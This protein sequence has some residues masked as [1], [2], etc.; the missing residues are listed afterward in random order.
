MDTTKKIITIISLFLLI[1]AGCGGECKKDSDCVKK[2]F[3]GSCQDKV[4]QYDPLPNC[5]GNNIKEN[6]EDGKPGNECTCPLDYGQCSAK[7]KSS[8]YIQYSCNADKTECNTDVKPSI[9]VETQQITDTF[10]GTGS[11]KFS[12]VSK[13]NQPFNI[14]KDTFQ[15]RIKLDQIPST[16]TSNVRIT[17]ITIT[18]TNSKRQTVTL[19]SKKI[20][21]NLWDLGSETQEDIIFDEISSNEEEELKSVK[22]KISYDYDY[23]SG[24]ATTKKTGTAENTI[25]LDKFIYLNPS[26]TRACPGSC[27][28]D[29]DATKDYCSKDTGFFCKHDPISGKC[30]NHECEAG[31]NPCTCQED[32][33]KCEGDIGMY[34]EKSCYKDSCVAAKKEGVTE[35]EETVLDEIKT[36]SFKVT[37]KYTY[38]QPFNLKESELKA[39]FTLETK[40]DDFSSFR[41]KYIRV[42]ESSKLLFEAK[43]SDI[44]KRF[45]SVGSSLEV[46]IKPDFTTASKEESKSITLEVG[47]EYEVQTTSGVDKKEGKK[48]KSLSKIDFISPDI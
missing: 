19:A 7:G 11:I 34:L 15:M 25:K 29:N 4:C 3:E 44:S 46:K 28:D 27:D 35:K 10:S 36:S 13:I 26:M 22:I 23:K 17:G 48:S 24:S 43:E 37:S 2:C 45:T 16:T 9:N 32:C 39:E 30:G 42:F 18:A 5:C 21:R 12:V 8:Q 14:D 6:T 38:Y 33:G 47:Y 20:D 40:E 31:E 41:I 1:L